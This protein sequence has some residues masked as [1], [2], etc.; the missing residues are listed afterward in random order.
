[1]VVLKRFHDGGTKKVPL[2]WIETDAFRVPF[3]IKL[4][5]INGYVKYFNDNKCIIF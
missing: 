1:M 4:P 5:P 3:F 2:W